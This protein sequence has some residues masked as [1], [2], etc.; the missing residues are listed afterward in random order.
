MH[1]WGWG[2]HS[3]PSMVPKHQRFGCTALLLGGGGGLGPYSNPLA[4]VMTP[5][6]E[7]VIAVC[8]CHSLAHAGVP[9]PSQCCAL[10]PACPLWAIGAPPTVTAHP[11]PPVALPPPPPYPTAPRACACAWRARRFFRAGPRSV[12]LWEVRAGVGGGPNVVVVCRA[13]VLWHVRA[14][15]CLCSTGSVLPHDDLHWAVPRGSAHCRR[16][17]HW[18]PSESLSSARTQPFAFCRSVISAPVT[19]KIQ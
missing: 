18:S 10:P 7:G 6:A 14:S 2:L 1:P 15:V 3:A 16:A 11:A 4:R 9:R 5:P 12:R 17:P 8:P 19:T 13:V